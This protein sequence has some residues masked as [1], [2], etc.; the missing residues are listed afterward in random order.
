MCMNEREIEQ[1]NRMGWRLAANW[2]ESETDYVWSQDGVDFYT[3]AEVCVDVLRA[4]IAR[5]REICA[6]NHDAAYDLRA[7]ILA[8][9]GGES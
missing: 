9:I 8:E 2:K 7:D 5:I 6:G 1:A 3:E 4:T